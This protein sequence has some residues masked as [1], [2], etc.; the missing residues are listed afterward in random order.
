MQIDDIA[1]RLGPRCPVAPERTGW[2]NAPLE[3]V[4]P[5]VHVFQYVAAPVTDTH[6]HVPASEPSQPSGAIDATAN[7]V[8]E[9]H[10]LPSEATSQPI[11]MG[12]VFGLG[13]GTVAVENRVVQPATMERPYPIRIA[14][15][16]VENE[17]HLEP[18]NSAWNGLVVARPKSFKI[19]EES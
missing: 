5:R 1:R 4:P 19:R 7:N 15:S 6:V 14:P 11:P 17:K 9:S 2:R 8:R 16:P 13:S 3:S 10:T 18:D 12:S